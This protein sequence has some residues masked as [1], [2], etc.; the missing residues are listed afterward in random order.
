VQVNGA[1][2]HFTL[3]TDASG[4]YQVWLDV[5]N[6]PLQ[7]IAAKD[8]FQPQVAKAKITKGGTT[9]LNFALLRD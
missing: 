1:T 2:T 7:V 9:T 4:H 3:K 6:N 8:G 5:A